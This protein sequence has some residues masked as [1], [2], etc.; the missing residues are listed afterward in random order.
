[1][2][3]GSAG[4]P[5]LPSEDS[6]RRLHLAIEKNKKDDVTKL[7]QA[8][9]ATA[10][11]LCE[12]PLSGVTA[13]HRSVK[14]PQLLKM[15]LQLTDVSPDA[16]ASTGQDSELP[17]TDGATPLHAAA[18]YGSADS[19]KVLLEHQAQLERLDGA[20]R[21][22]LH[23]AASQNQAKVAL[24]L[25]K[26]GTSP[27]AQTRVGRT[28]L[29][30]CASRNS[31][32]TAITLLENGVLVDERD[33]QGCTALHL[34]AHTGHA[35]IVEVLLKAGADLTVTTSDKGLTAAMLAAWHSHSRVLALLLEKNVAAAIGGYDHD[36]RGL[37][38]VA[39]RRADVMIIEMV[40][41]YGGASTVAATD[42]FGRTALHLAVYRSDCEG[43]I[44][45]LAANG[46]D[47]NSLDDRGRTPLHLA[48]AGGN[49]AA[50]NRLLRHGAITDVIDL[51]GC[52]ALDYAKGGKLRSA[53]RAGRKGSAMTGAHTPS[54]GAVGAQYRLV[55][56]MLGGGGSAASADTH[57]LLSQPAHTSPSMLTLGEVGRSEAAHSAAPDSNDR[58]R[59]A[60]MQH[61]VEDILATGEAVLR[62][63]VQRDIAH[64]KREVRTLYTDARRAAR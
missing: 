12:A 31:Q 63:G 60:Q 15:M 44:D 20:G 29:H 19:V 55:P 21:T 28:P 30:V 41:K 38:H 6:I 14:N 61:E 49:E 27:N 45:V 54:T 47:I 43:A 18:F 33:A 26:A 48:A 5:L 37:L 42:V 4:S 46:I 23:M 16:A 52:T 17:F 56:P 35:S 64:M 1:M 10:V 53:L 32:Q 36:G 8:A 13:L 25:L 58:T 34:A 57:S 9:G 24:Q 7:L 22:P 62:Q 2:P 50:V 39:A 59:L 11:Q 51:R 40:I 3:E